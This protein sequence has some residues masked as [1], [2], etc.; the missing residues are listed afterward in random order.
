MR[1]AGGVGRPRQLGPSFQRIVQNSKPTGSFSNN[2][3][4]PSAFASPAAGVQIAVAWAATAVIL[5]VYYP[6]ELQELN[7]QRVRTVHSFGANELPRAMEDATAFG[8]EALKLLTWGLFLG[9]LSGGCLSGCLQSMPRWL[10]LLLLTPLLVV[11]AS[12]AMEFVAS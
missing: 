8:W 4:L 2:S 3:F 12:L 10:S 11:L 9:T 6:K 1:A 7:Q 5:A